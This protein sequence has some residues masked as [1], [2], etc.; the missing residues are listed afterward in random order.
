MRQT[1]VAK[2]YLRQILQDLPRHLSL[3]ITSN[4][5]LTCKHLSTWSYL[6]L[7]LLSLLSLL[8][9]WGPNRTKANIISHQSNKST[10]TTL[11][12]LLGSHSDFFSTQ[13]QVMVYR[14]SL[15]ISPQLKPS[16]SS[17]VLKQ[18]ES[19]SHGLGSFAPSAP[20]TLSATPH[21]HSLV[22]LCFLLTV[23]QSVPH[24][25]D[26]RFLHMLSPLRGTGFVFPSSLMLPHLSGQT[27]CPYRSLAWRLCH[28][29]LAH[30]PLYGNILSEPSVRR[31]FEQR[32]V[33][34]AGQRGPIPCTNYS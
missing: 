20:C 5:S 24:M 3:T 14:K 25:Y 13:P 12:C 32:S 27:A 1:D 18:D 19:P 8:F 26:H 15:I 7:L 23:F 6:L 4:A 16:V 30:P 9:F 33:G 17:I 10:V 22:F 29:H 2:S 31:S 28:L 34:L 21:P 11:L